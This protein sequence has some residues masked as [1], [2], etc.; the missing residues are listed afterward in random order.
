MK[1]VA[2]TLWLLLLFIGSILFFTHRLGESEKEGDVLNDLTL[3]VSS[4]ANESMSKNLVSDNIVQLENQLNTYLEDY[5]IADS[6][7]IVVENFVEEETYVHNEEIDFFSASLYKVPL[8]MLYYDYINSG[9]YT[10]DDV[11]LYEE[12][13]YI[14]DGGIGDVYTIGDAIDL[15]TL[16]DSMIIY[17]DNTAAHILF[18]SLGGWLAFK[19]QI[20]KY[21]YQK[22]EEHFY[23]QYDNVFSADYLSDVLSYLY[24][25]KMSYKSLLENMSSQT[26]ND[27]LGDYDSYV[28]AQ[29]YGKYETVRNAMGILYKE[30]TQGIAYS[31]VILSELD[32]IGEEHIAYIN[33]LCMQYF[34]DK[35]Y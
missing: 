10:Y 22:Q 28:V 34:E 2:M 19:S 24:A 15:K 3:D 13:H 23:T 6:I 31:I 20:A 26:Y 33:Q 21:S 9:V 16:L 18:E 29:K 27:Y 17:S 11:F 35:S 25:N 14:A 5:G 1:K 7:A 12:K 30:H 32:A 8:A 4:H